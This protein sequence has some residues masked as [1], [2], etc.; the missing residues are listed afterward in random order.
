MAGYQE[1]SSS[2]STRNPVFDVYLSRKA[3]TTR[4]PYDF[5][6][7]GIFN[8]GTTASPKFA[9]NYFGANSQLNPIA[10]NAG[11]IEQQQG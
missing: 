8:K 11:H 6:N 10:A 7:F 2:S 9:Q 5:N 3:A 4:N 1:P